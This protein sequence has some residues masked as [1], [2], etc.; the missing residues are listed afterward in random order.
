M[1]HKLFFLIALFLIGVAGSALTIARRYRNADEKSGRVI[2]GFT[3]F[4]IFLWLILGFI[5]L[6]S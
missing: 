5:I 1:D 3:M 2:A 6:G 4:F